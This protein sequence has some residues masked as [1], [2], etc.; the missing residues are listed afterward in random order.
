MYMQPPPVISYGPSAVVPAW[1][2][3]IAVL[4]NQIFDCTDE[5]EKTVLEEALLKELQVHC[6]RLTLLIDLEP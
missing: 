6:V 2:V 3:P 1:D 4:T 5:W